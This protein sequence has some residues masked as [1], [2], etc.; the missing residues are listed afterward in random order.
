MPCRG[1]THLA[2]EVDT[3]MRKLMFLIV[4]I[5]SGRIVGHAQ[6]MGTLRGTVVD[7]QNA[8]VQGASVTLKAH[9][10]AFTKTTHTDAAGVFTFTTVFAN[11]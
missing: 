6:I 1:L 2:I 10:S 3:S 11:T 4:L 5:A 8:V 9:D 7:A